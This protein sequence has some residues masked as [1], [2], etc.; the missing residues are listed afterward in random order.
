MFLLTP[1]RAGAAIIYVDADA[2][3]AGTG[4]SWADAFVYL[5]DALAAAA[6][7]DEIWVA[8]GTYYPDE[9]G[10]KTDGDRTSTFEIRG[11]KFIYGGFDG[12]DGAGGGA[13]E[14]E[15]T[16]REPK[17][18]VTVLSG[19]LDQN[20]DGFNNNDNNAYHVVTS[21]SANPI[22]IDGFTIKAGNANGSDDNND[23]GGVFIS[24]PGPYTDRFYPIIENCVIVGNSAFS[25]GGIHNRN[26]HSQIYNCVISGNRASEGGGMYNYGGYGSNPTLSNCVFSGNSATSDGGALYNYAYPAADSNPTLSNC[27]FSGNSATSDGGAIYNEGYYGVSSPELTNCSFGGNSAANGRSLYNAVST[28]MGAGACAPVLTNC[29]LW[30]DSAIYKGTNTAPTYTYCDIKGSGGSASWNASLGT[31]LGGNIDVDPLFVDPP[32]PGAAP[33]TDGDVH[34]QAGSPCIDAGTGTGAPAMD[35]DGNTRDALPDIGAD[36]WVLDTDGDGE[37]D[38]TDGCPY[39]ASK[40]DPGVC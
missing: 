17:K 3:G 4:T 5:Q 15:R 38:E 23:G 11:N 26:I 36:E 28:A 6:L 27:V 24:I 40:I 29:I 1:I 16:Q 35:L 30:D 18:N 13:L 31:D 25:G 19:D 33:T 20:D 10:G 32:D 14:S 39:D 7:N 2:T 34:L 22:E 21:G 8:A 9:G 37:P 12:T